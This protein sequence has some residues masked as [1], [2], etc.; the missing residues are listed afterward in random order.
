MMNGINVRNG[1]PHALGKVVQWLEDSGF[2]VR[3]S[4]ANKDGT[5]SIF[6]MRALTNEEVSKMREVITRHNPRISVERI[7]RR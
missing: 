1:K 3:N 4:T 6:F 5:R 2:P 7:I